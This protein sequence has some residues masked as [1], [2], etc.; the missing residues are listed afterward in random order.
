MAAQRFG[1]ETFPALGSR[2]LAADHIDVW[3]VDTGE[4]RDDLLS[5]EERR[6]AD[7]FS[8]DRLRRRY[9]GAHDALRRI[10][11]AYTGTPPQ[12]LAFTENASG[13][14]V[15]LG[16]E[17]LHFN[18]SHSGDRAAVAVSRQAVGVDIEEMKA[19]PP[20]ETAPFFLTGDEQ[21]RLSAANDPA[22]RVMF[23][24]FWSAK[25]AVAKGLGLGLDLDFRRIVIGDPART[26]P[27]EVPFEAD[28]RDWFLHPL[29]APPGFSAALA[30]PLRTMRL[31]L[32]PL[33]SATSRNFA[34]DR[35]SSRTAEIPGPPGA[36]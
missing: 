7:G 30:S 34:Q 1:P 5:A 36:C 21:A 28:G 35:K 9:C 4:G 11:S 29:P 24:R 19:E 22:R 12:S 17:A 33:A 26:G 31:R 16:V 2:R 25:E 32:Y 15:L 10:L 18:L 6:R 3:F 27:V 13:K 8:T 14:P 23:Y 20:Y